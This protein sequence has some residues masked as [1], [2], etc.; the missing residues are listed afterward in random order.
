MAVE[1]ENKERIGFPYSLCKFKSS[2]SLEH[3]IMS[4]S[5]S[6]RTKTSFYFMILE[7]CVKQESTFSAALQLK[8]FKYFKS[9]NVLLH[10]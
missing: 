1:K 7:N 9:S 6:F 2:I 10:Q 3:N 8:C 5:C 4:Q